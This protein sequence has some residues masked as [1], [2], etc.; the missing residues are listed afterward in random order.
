MVVSSTGER[1]QPR[2]FAGRPPVWFFLLYGFL[3][4]FAITAPI[5]GRHQFSFL[6]TLGVVVRACVEYLAYM[7]RRVCFSADSLTYSS[8]EGVFEFKFDQ[9]DKI[10]PTSGGDQLRFRLVSG[11][12]RVIHGPMKDWELMCAH[13][14]EHV[15]SARW[16]SR[17]RG[18]AI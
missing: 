1:G 16:P 4:P 15:E 18:Q 8:L 12:D 10:W 17:L 11:E 3:V 14:E 13:F 5:V 9:I 6:I 7:R 2:V